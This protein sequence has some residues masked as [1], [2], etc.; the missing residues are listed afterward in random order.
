MSNE[1]CPASVLLIEDDERWRETIG[2]FLEARGYSTVLAEGCE[3][4]FELL[5]R[6]DRPCLVLVDPLTLAIDCDRLLRALGPND[7]MATLPMVLVSIR[8]PE[9]FSRPGV[10]KKPANLDLL[11][12]MVKEHCCG[13]SGGKR[14]LGGSEQVHD[15]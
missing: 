3:Q 15:L 9:L 1:T 13:G 6:I 14:T 11:L 2:A 7:R 10:V 5:R 8:A 12:R 4:A